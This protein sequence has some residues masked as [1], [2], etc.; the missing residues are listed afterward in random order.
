VPNASRVGGWGLG[1]CAYDEGKNEG[2]KGG[3]FT[4]LDAAK[5]PT[6]NNFPLE[7]KGSLGREIRP[8]HGDYMDI[9]LRSEE[10][11]YK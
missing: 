3:A 6:Q 5:F 11:R 4:L 10:R 1:R 7:N 9:E 2:E 8:S